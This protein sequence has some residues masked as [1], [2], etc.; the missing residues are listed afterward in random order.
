MLKAEKLNI[1]IW[2]CGYNKQDEESL[3]FRAQKD[4][5]SH[6]P[7]NW[8][9]YKRNVKFLRPGMEYLKQFSVNY[10]RVKIYCYGANAGSI[11]IDEV[12][13]WQ[14]EE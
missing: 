3:V 10:A 4:V 1:K 9:E 14:K 11:Y 8:Q 2:T 13:L 5:V 6:H 7:E 12:K